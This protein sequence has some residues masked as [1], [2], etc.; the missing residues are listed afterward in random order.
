MS[1][2]I[3]GLDIPEKDSVI[4]EIDEYGEVCEHIGDGQPIHIK[5]WATAIQQK[6]GAWIDKGDLKCS[7]CG[8]EFPDLYP[9]YSQAKY[10][11]NCGARLEGYI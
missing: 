9:L 5:P 3:E 4:I 10:C 6:K 11:P 2:I 7:I 8:I 1:I